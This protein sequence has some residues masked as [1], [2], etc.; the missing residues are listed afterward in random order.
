[1]RHS[2][3]DRR[4]NIRSGGR[5]ILP[6]GA[7]LT[8]GG[9]LSGS[10]A[11]T[12]EVER[13]R[14]ERAERLELLGD[15]RMPANRLPA[16]NIQVRLCELKVEVR[17]ARL[18]LTRTPKWDDSFRRGVGEHSLCHEGACAVVRALSQGGI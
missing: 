4:T 12:I 5:R 16:P 10:R 9:G 17:G 14:D 2:R 7:S 3:Q 6:A 18:A 13:A 8:A 11:R 15:E 1:M